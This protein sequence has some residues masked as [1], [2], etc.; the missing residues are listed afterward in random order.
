MLQ[1]GMRA[2]EGER[3]LAVDVM[4]WQCMQCTS[5]LLINFWPRPCS[6]RC[7]YAK[8][9]YLRK[10]RLASLLQSFQRS[11]VCFGNG[12]C[13]LWKKLQQLHLV[14]PVWQKHRL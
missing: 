9:N 10:N 7:T 11:P 6:H 12:S 3:A 1:V 2:A 8:P 5:F 14:Q 4:H 13:Q